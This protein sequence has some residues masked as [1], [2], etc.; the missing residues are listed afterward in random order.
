VR[1]EVGVRVEVRLVGQPVQ[2]LA[3]PGDSRHRQRVG[4]EDVDNGGNAAA[5][6]FRRARFGVADD[7]L[8]VSI[9]LMQFSAGITKSR[10]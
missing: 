6:A 10:R 7:R 5:G 1:D 9:F 4:V 8:D 2:R 3:G